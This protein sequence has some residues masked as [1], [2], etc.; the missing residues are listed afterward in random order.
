[1]DKKRETAESK[2]KQ[3]REQK[4]TAIKSRVMLKIAIIEKQ[5]EKINEMQ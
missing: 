2:I 5:C 1:M 3:N 4:R